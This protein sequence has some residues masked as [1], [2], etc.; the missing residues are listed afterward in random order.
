VLF[1]V[2]IVAGITV[3]TFR[4]ARLSKVNSSQIRKSI[5]TMVDF[6]RPTIMELGETEHFDTSGLSL[7]LYWLAEGR[8][9]GG[10]VVICS[11]SLQFQSLIELVR[12]PSCTTVYSSL[13]EALDALCQF[14]TVANSG[15]PSPTNGTRCARAALAG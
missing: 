10:T 9:L 1:E 3:V 8:R 4:V 2:S 13:S 11:D 5:A 12:I 6:R 7:I 15:D 14:A